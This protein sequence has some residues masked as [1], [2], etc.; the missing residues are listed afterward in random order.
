MSDERY[1]V[2]VINPWD[3]LEI[4]PVNALVPVT[5]LPMQT[6]SIGFIP[7]FATREAAEEWADGAEVL[8]IR[9]VER[10]AA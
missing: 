10:V 7:V 9:L 2:M 4:A 5:V 1:V 3:S 8:A 6:T